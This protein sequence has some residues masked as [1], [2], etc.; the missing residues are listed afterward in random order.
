MKRS[1]VV[2]FAIFL[3]LIGIVGPA[4]AVVIDFTGGTAY[5]N[6][7]GTATPANLGYYYVDYYV[8]DGMKFDFVGGN[9]YGIIGDYYNVLLQGDNYNTPNDS[10]AH[11][12]VIHAHWQPDIAQVTSMVIT[13]VDGGAFNLN[14]ID[15]TSNTMADGSKKTGGELS[16]ITNNSGDF[17]L[18]SGSD[19]GFD[20]IWGG[21]SGDGVFTQSLDSH[22]DGVT[23]VTFTST[24][25]YCFGLDSVSVSVPEPATLLLLGLGLI[26]VAAVRRKF[27]K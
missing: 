26:G 7:G 16:Y 3:L 11:N 8:E 9:G 21:V 19:W 6:G 1:I 17:V 25:A 13:R 18:L 27:K 12:D 5:L 14:Y 2:A 20:K 4:D 23:A 24:N 22:F 10:S 15:I